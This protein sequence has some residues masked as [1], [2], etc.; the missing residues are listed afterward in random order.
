MRC[1]AVA[2]TFINA[3]L[4]L[5]PNHRA[6]LP[7]PPPPPKKITTPPRPAPPHTP[8][9]ATPDDIAALTL[10]ATHPLHA[11]AKGGIHAIDAAPDPEEALV[12]TAGDD[13]K[14]CV[15]DRS[16]GRIVGELKG[17]SKKVLG[18][19]PCVRV[20]VRMSLSLSL[21]L[22]LCVCVCAC[23]CVRVC[24]CVCVHACV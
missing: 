6:P 3:Y 24:A 2:V 4:H 17:H 23:V 11:A 1:G 19:C 18:E 16:A 14:V 12:A 8:Q 5:L 7:L 9:V 22:S 10:T 20:C 13:G 21:S 15:F